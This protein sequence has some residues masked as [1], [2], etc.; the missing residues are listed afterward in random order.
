M[1]PE[2]MDE[3]ILS[4]SL[5]ETWESL[6]G[7]LNLPEPLFEKTL[8]CLGF[9]FSSNSYLIQ[10]EYLTLIDPG[11]DYTAFMDL[12]ALG[13]KPTDIKKIVLTHG[14]VDH[15][16]G[17]FELFRGYPGSSENLDLEII[18]HEAGPKE[19][20][21]LA[22]QMG[23]RLTEIKGGE[24]LNLSGFDLEVI[25]TPGHT[26]DGIC[27]YH[28]PSRTMFTGDT[29]MPHAMA[30]MDPS[31]GGRLDHYLYSIRTLLKK[32]IENIMPGHGGIVGRIGRGIVMDTFEGLIRKVVGLETPWMEGAAKLAQ[33]GLMEEAVFCCNKE[34]AASPENFA[35][36]EMKAFLLIDLGRN[37]EAVEFLDKILAPQPGHFYALLGK[38]SALMG[39]GDYQGSLAYFDRALAINPHHQETLINRG[40]A[41]YLCGRFDEAMDIEIFQR[42]F[43]SRLK[44]EFQAEP[45]SPASR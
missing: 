31:A 9:D 18:L 19:F 8:F 38:G 43:T 42:E 45:P 11:N 35:A 3:E 28:A 24:T 41:L 21:E 20:K 33:Q 5:D 32:N 26:L 2:Y 14:H 30:E 16:M 23:C 10:G 22:G 36:L 37:A 34:L 17:T 7:L 44:Q 39:L 27:L 40:M 1:T 29:V 25:H 15:A 13:F 12:F 4:R 6:A